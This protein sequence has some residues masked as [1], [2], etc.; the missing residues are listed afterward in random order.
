MGC[1]ADV[2]LGKGLTLPAKQVE[3]LHRQLIRVLPAIIAKNLL[4]P[5][6]M[7]AKTRSR[8]FCIVN[9]PI[10]VVGEPDFDVVLG[11]VE[12]YILSKSNLK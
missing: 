11:A 3:H 12:A 9:P 5:V 1:P 8:E 10:Q 6:G 7:L 2:Q 4:I